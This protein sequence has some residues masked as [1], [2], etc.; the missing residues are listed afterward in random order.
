MIIEEN[1]FHDMEVI[2]MILKY[3]EKQVDFGEIQNLE[4][5]RKGFHIVESKNLYRVNGEGELVLLEEAS[6]SK[7]LK[8]GDKLEA[9]SEFSLG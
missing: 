7:K 9:I 6:F 2:S 4:Q 1:N 3:G 5:I 8:E